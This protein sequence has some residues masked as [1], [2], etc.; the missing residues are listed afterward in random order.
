M[1]L[2]L[3][4]RSITTKPSTANSVPEPERTLTPRG[5]RRARR[6]ARGLRFLKVAPEL[7]LT[8]PL[9]RAVQT[10]KLVA[11]QLGIGKDKIQKTLTLAPEATPQAFFDELAGR[12]EASVLCVGHAPHID[13]ALVKSLGTRESCFSKL[14]PAGA[15]CVEMDEVAPRRG[16]LVWLLEP[17]ALRLAGRRCRKK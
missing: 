6:A 10:A 12:K 16:K 15:A 4:R 8:S 14:K 9:P 11:R 7:I 2:Y 13:L 1:K 5:I 17:R 3:L